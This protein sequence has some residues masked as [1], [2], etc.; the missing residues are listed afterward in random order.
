MVIQNHKKSSIFVTKT[1]RLFGTCHAR[2]L[3]IVLIA[4][5]LTANG[6]AVSTTV[7]TMVMIIIQIQRFS[8]LLDR[9]G[10]VVIPKTYVALIKTH[11]IQWVFRQI[12]RPNKF[13]QA[14]FVST[15]MILVGIIPK[16]ISND[17]KRK[18]QN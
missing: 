7:N 14:T 15:Q 8:S 16:S 12:I 5:W 18:T 10:P 3:K 13:Q 2:N 1:L 17:R 6:I 11:S 4:H 9:L